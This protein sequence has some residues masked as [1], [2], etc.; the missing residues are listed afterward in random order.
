MTISVD[1]VAPVSARLTLGNVNYRLADLDSCDTRY[2]HL[3][4]VVASVGKVDTVGKVA[5][6]CRRARLR[7]E[8]PVA[9]GVILGI[10]RSV[11]KSLLFF[12]KQ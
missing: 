3:R 7:V 12:E 1:K 11:T 10:V 9:V 2:T 4:Y 8:T 5:Q 6:S